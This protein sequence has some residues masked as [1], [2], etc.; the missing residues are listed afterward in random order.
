MWKTEIVLHVIGG[1]CCHDLD[2]LPVANN[3]G[4]GGPT[5][6]AGPNAIAMNYCLSNPSTFRLSNDGRRLIVMTPAPT[7]AGEGLGRRADHSRERNNLLVL[8]WFPVFRCWTE[9]PRFHD[10]QRFR[11]EHGFAHRARRHEAAHRFH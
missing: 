7:D 5:S 10:R 1:A 6:H 8:H 9:P 4:D 3:R 11:E 2:E